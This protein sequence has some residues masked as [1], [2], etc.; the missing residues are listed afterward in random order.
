[1]YMYMKCG[2]ETVREDDRREKIKRDRERESW[3][4]GSAQEAACSLT[5]LF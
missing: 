4:A 3:F 1:M 5:A 2:D